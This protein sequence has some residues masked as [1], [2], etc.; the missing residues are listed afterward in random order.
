M[1]DTGI[2]GD[3]MTHRKDRSKGRTVKK[4]R[5]KRVMSPEAAGAKAAPAKEQQ[6]V[7]VDLGELATNNQVDELEKEIGAWKHDVLVHG[8]GK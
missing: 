1:L 5:R 4:E 2:Q 6:P 8:V 7:K 3:M